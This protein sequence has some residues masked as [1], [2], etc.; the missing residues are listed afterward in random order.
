MAI[1]LLLAEELAYEAHANQ[2]RK[3]GKTPYIEHVKAVVSK[4]NDD[5]GKIVAWLH[6][7]I[8]DSHFNE[9]DLLNRGFPSYIVDAVSLL[10]KRPGIQYFEYLSNVKKNDLARRVKVVDMLHNLSDDPSVSQIIKY[11][12][13]LLFL[14]GVE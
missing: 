4:L 3:D 8:E 12:K 9:L 14:I 2:F 10:T 6:D 13:G 11:C 1:I 7:V 5:D